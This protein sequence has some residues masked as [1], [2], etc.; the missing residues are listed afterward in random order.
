M[1]PYVGIA[2]DFGSYNVFLNQDGG[3]TLCVCEACATDA[4]F[5]S[6]WCVASVVSGPRVGMASLWKHGFRKW[7]FHP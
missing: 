2:K 1:R 3:Y 6:L 5:D 7:T 4:A